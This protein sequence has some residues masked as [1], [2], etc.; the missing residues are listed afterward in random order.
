[1]PT[2]S[3]SS[4]RAASSQRL[5]GGDDAADGDVPPARATGPWRRCAGGRAAARR[6]TC[7]TTNTAR[8]RSRSARIRARVTVATTRSSLVDDVDQLVAR[9]RLASRLR[10]YHARMPVD[11]ASLREE[12]NDLLEPDRRAA[13]HAAP[14][15]GGRQRPADHP[16]ARA[17]RARGPA[18][19][20][21]RRTRR[22]AG[23]PRCSPAA[24][25]GP[26]ILLRGDMDALPMPEDTGLDFASQGRRHDARL[27]PRH[28]HG[29]ARRRGQAARRRA[30]T[31]W[32]GGCCSCS[33]PARRATTAPGSCSTRACSTCPHAG[34]RHARRRSTR[35]F[36]LHITS[37]L[38][39]GWLSSRA[40][41]DHGVGRHAC[42]ITVTGKGG[43][44]SEPHRAAR[45]D[46]GR[47]RDRPG[48]AA[49]GHP[50]GSTCSTR[51][52]SPS[53]GSRAGT[54]NNVIPETAE[55]EGTIRAVSEK[56]RAKVHDGIRRV[57]DGIAAAHGCDGRGRRSSSATRSRSTTTTSPSSRSASPTT[58]SAPTRSSACPTR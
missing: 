13:P 15:A 4:R 24:E 32:P 6:S 25:P 51:P 55:I 40:G 28:P 19:R 2:S 33:S 39:S 42:T 14:V 56:T 1:M 58:S 8:W 7:T 47:V 30:A 20:R 36:A 46:P 3:A 52:S 23:S 57:A 48:A 22:R 34:R 26:T 41:P 10:A 50:R 49:D 45:P 5:A 17:R 12:A 38:P 9:Q 18:A 29:D 27:R 44:A 43:H 11:T 16:R 21:H 53:G 35:A 37:A 31:T 54:T